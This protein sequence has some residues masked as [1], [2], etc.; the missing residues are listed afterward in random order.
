MGALFFSKPLLPHRPAEH[1][2]D[3]EGSRPAYLRVIGPPL[4][5]INKELS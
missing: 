5:Q 2:G 1:A 4:L 3:R